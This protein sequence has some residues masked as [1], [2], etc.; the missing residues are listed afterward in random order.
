[1]ASLRVC[2]V[3]TGAH[4]R[5][6]QDHHVALTWTREPTETRLNRFTAPRC[7]DTSQVARMRRARALEVR[8][9]P[10]PAGAHSGGGGA[11]PIAGGALGC[12]HELA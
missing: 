2:H 1:M 8:T 3:P 5:N 9:A 11:L 10:A 7:S 12:R 6:T 4:A